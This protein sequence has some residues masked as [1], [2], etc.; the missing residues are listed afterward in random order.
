VGTPY[1]KMSKEYSLICPSERE[2]KK[3]ILK[4]VVPD[5]WVFAKIGG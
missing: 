4:I 2:Q 3:S 1:G 5:N